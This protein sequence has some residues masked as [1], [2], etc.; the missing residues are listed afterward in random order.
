MYTSHVTN[1]YLNEIVRLFGVLRTINWNNN[2][3]LL[4]H[5]WKIL[6]SKLGTKLQFNSTVHSQTNGQ[7]KVVI[8][9]RCFVEKNIR[10]W[11][12]IIPQV[13]FAYK[14][15]KQ[16]TGNNWSQI[17]YSK[18]LLTLLELIHIVPSIEYS[19]DAEVKMKKIK[20]LHKLVHGEIAKQNAKY[21]KQAK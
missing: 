5:F 14:S 4:S 17:I 3:K 8:F 6:W 18:N 1:L 16:F 7:T 9:L 21:Q 2:V 10:Q 19:I 12:L 13:K 11:N 20:S 15:S